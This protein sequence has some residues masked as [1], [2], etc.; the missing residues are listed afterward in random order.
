MISNQLVIFDII[1]GLKPTDEKTI[2]TFE[3]S[4]LDLLD[5]IENILKKTKNVF[6][7]FMICS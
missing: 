2:E 6:Y 7:G 5:S 4:I 3:I 1:L